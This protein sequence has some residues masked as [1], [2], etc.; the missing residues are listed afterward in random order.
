MI[1]IAKPRALGRTSIGVGETLG[2]KRGALPSKQKVYFKCIIWIGQP[3][4]R[5]AFLCRA[6]VSRE[7]HK[8]RS[9]GLFGRCLNSLLPASAIA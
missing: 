7:V 2:T 6:P 1:L 3:D 8:G 5:V 4:C 9:G